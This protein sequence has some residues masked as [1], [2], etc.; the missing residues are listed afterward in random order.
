MAVSVIFGP[1][2]VPL[3]LLT[4]P[5]GILAL[6]RSALAWDDVTSRQLPDRTSFAW[7]A[8]HA[9]SASRGT[10][11]GARVSRCAGRSPIASNVAGLFLDEVSGR[12]RQSSHSQQAATH[13]VHFGQYSNFGMR[14]EHLAHATSLPAPW[15]SS[16]AAHGRTGRPCQPQRANS[17]RS[18]ARTRCRR[19]TDDAVLPG[20]SA[21]R[22]AAVRHRTASASARVRAARAH[23][24][25]RHA[26]GARGR[27]RW[28]RPGR[29]RSDLDGALCFA[30]VFCRFFLRRRRRAVSR[31]PRSLAQARR[32]APHTAV[33]H[34]ATQPIVLTAQPTVLRVL[35]EHPST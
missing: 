20:C 26:Q 10:R 7:R 4:L 23:G 18:G 32:T 34:A 5:T 1:N 28:Q 35:T 33:R 19:R 17:R 16:R 8:P 15:R 12:F 31:G 29:L 3:S 14:L 22:L 6:P 27:A 13:N 9:A 24:R 2:V 30:L 25:L 21:V 11:P